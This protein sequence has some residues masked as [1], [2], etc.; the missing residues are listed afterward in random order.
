MHR[1]F[2]QS[3]ASLAT[4]GGLYS[5]AKDY[6]ARALPGLFC[7]SR[8]GRNRAGAAAAEADQAQHSPRERAMAARTIAM[9]VALSNIAPLGRH[10][11][12]AHVRIVWRARVPPALKIFSLVVAVVSLRIAALCGYLAERQGRQRAEAEN[13]RVLNNRRRQPPKAA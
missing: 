5:T 9:L 3:S 8:N 11:R 1:R 12:H 10:I 6:I 7:S 2:A 13:D 4:C